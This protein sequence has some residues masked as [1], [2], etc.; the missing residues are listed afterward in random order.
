MKNE[1]GQPLIENEKG[2]ESLLKTSGSR[3]NF[4]ETIFQK[5]KKLV[6]NKLNEY[7]LAGSHLAKADPVEKTKI[8][9]F[10]D[11]NSSGDQS[12]SWVWSTF[13]T[14]YKSNEEVPVE[15]TFNIIISR[16]HVERS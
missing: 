5:Q 3:P 10:N 2:R 1:G 15:S 8:I 16:V 14:Q 12:S 4:N 9:I 11:P 7:K 13:D 6:Q